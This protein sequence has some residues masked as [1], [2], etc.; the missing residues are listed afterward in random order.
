[1]RARDNNEAFIRIK[2]NMQEQLCWDDSMKKRIIPHVGD[3][4][5]PQL[6]MSPQKRDELIQ[7][8]STVDAVYHAGALVNWILSYNQL[9]ET[10]V[11]GMSEILKLIAASNRKIP[12]HY[13]STIGVTNLGNFIFFIIKNAIFYELI[14]YYRSCTC[15]KGLLRILLNWRIH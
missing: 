11:F 10:N 5:L 9:R 8:L 6:G 3:L 15:F 1:M 2:N 14:I 4:S 13:V 12:F 7:L